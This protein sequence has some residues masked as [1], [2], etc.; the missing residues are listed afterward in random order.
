VGAYLDVEEVLSQHGGAVVDGDAGTIELAAEHLS[1]N[2]H[3]QHVAGEFHVGLQ[4][5]DV[6]S[7]FEDL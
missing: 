2:G 1:R 6:G 7:A 3:A 4:V 5:V